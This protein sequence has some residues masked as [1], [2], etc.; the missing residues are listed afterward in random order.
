[1][2]SKVCARGR[3]VQGLL[4]YLFTEGRA[5]EKS[6]SSDHD[7]PRVIAGFDD[8]SLLQPEAR[9]DGR[10]DF[11]RLAGL[12]TQPLKLAGVGP[13]DRPVYHLVASAAKDPQTG[14]LRDRLLTD[15]Q[16]ADIAAEYL[17]QLG[18]ARPGDE[19][20]AR[21]VAVRHADDHVHIVATLARQ[22]GKRI[23]PHN[24]YYTVRRASHAIEA[25]YG[26]TSTAPADRTAAKR[27]TR[28]ETEKLARTRQHRSAHAAAGPGLTDRERLRRHVRTAAAGSHNLPEFLARLEHDGVLVRLRHSEQNPDQVTGYAVALPQ[29]NGQPPVWFGGGKLAPDLTLPQLQHRFHGPDARGQER[30][31]RGRQWT[32]GKTAY[33]ERARHR[34]RVEASPLSPGER[35]RA[36]RQATAAAT[37]ATEHISRC[38]RTDPAGAADAAWAAAD[39]LTV[40]AQLVEGRAGGTL[41]DAAE[42]YD[43]AARE[44]HGRRPVLTGA[45][46]GLRHAAIALLD[47]GLTAQLRH[48]NP[49]LAA[50]LDS[51]TALVRAVR[52]LRETQARLAQAQAARLAASRLTRAASAAVVD[53]EP[54]GPSSSRYSSRGA[55]LRA[56]A[57]PEA[58]SPGVPSTPSAGSPW[59]VSHPSVGPP[60]PRRSRSR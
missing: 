20:G 13:D 7:N 58:V 45:G 36:W 14:Q 3:R 26:L 6:L 10:R 9:P 52:E 33:D 22:D 42:A 18:F 1:V 23:H 55:A 51:L 47:A 11:R 12:L 2:I 40:T 30:L 35:V 57:F 50:L 31:A 38:A 56:I 48:T 5:G 44:L 53:V 21:W 29:P 54:S 32:A 46:H 8:P 59:R 24:D 41:T 49:E 25:R 4:Y 37:R 39:L 16:W 19:L 27:P 15:D 17:H 43:R 34:A 60:E 28:A